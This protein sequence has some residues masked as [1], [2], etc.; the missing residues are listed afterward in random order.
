MRTITLGRLLLAAAVVASSWGCQPGAG[1]PTPLVAVKG[2]VTYKGKP[3]TTGS[4]KFIPD[5][6]GHEAGGAIQSD[7]TFVLST[8]KSGDGVVEGHHRVY[9]TGLGREFARDRKML[10][11]T[12]PNTSDLSADV[13]STNTEFT[14]ELN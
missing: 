6:Y 12:S 3:L 10:K 4:V 1:D 14:F 11:Y 9:V 13:S 5:G 7:G 8:F 2:K